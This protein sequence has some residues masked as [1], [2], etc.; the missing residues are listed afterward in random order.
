MAVL[1]NIYHPPAYDKPLFSEQE[2]RK[3]NQL[4]G[5]A[6]TNRSICQRLVNQRDAT[7]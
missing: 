6:L 1:R 4:V 2:L 3:L 7:L 5:A